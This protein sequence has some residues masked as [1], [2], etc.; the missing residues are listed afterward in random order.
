MMLQTPLRPNSKLKMEEYFLHWVHEANNRIAVRRF[1]SLCRVVFKNHRI[2][3][4][5][6][7]LRLD[8]FQKRSQYFNNVSHFF[9]S[10]SLFSVCDAD[11]ERVSS[12]GGRS[13]EC[14]VVVV[15]DS[16]WFAGSKQK[17]YQPRAAEV[18]DEE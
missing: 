10:S 16:V 2:D 18:A 11:I 3:D 8:I 6:R 9:S 4:S 5:S 15:V 12:R 7:F 13:G 1:F 17:Q 14:D